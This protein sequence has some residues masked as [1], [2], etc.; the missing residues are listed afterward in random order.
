MAALLFVVTSLWLP[1]W[2]ITLTVE[3]AE[4]GLVTD[5]HLWNGSAPEANGWATIVTGIL[6][7]AALLVLFVRLA[8]RSFRMEPPAWRRDLTAVVFILVLAL[9][10]T[11]L[12][13]AEFPSFWGGR[14][15]VYEDGSFPPT[16]ETAMPALGWW[17]A[18]LAGACAAVARWMARPTTGK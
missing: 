2:R 4:G 10:S 8:A 17:M 18:V 7:V 5:T 15:T 16:T 11:L 9:A 6:V 1:W 12:W 13:P 3:G 14:T